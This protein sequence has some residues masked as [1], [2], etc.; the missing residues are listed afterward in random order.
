VSVCVFFFQILEKLLERH[1]HC[2][3]AADVKSIADDTHAFV[4][5]DL[6]GLVNTG[7]TNNYVFLTC[8]P[9]QI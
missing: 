1:P 5:D 7:N 8:V 9:L 3:S 4:G 2:L 6:L